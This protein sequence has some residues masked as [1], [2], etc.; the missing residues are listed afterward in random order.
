MLE[1]RKTPL[2]E[3]HVEAGGR[4]VDFGG[5]ALPVQYTSILEE[6]RA[7]RERAGLFDVSHMGEIH[8][9]GPDA[10]AFIQ[11]LVT[12][13]CSQMQVHQIV[14]SP[15]CYPDGGVVDDILVY[16]VC[17]NAYWL[18]VNA[19]NT[20]KDYEW[21]VRNAPGYDVTVKNISSQVA[22][23]AVQGPAAQTILQ[24]NTDYDLDS[25]KFFWCAPEAMI[26]ERKCLVSRTGYTGED[27]FEIYVAAAEAGRL[28]DRLLE[29]GAE[30]GLRP[31]GLGARDTLRLEAGFMLY[32]NELDESVNPFE[33]VYGRLVDFGKV[34]V[35][36]DA[37]LAARD[38]PATRRL[39]GFALEGRGIARHGYEILREGRVVGVVTSGSFAPT[40]EQSVGM[41]FVPPALAEPGTALE[42]RIRSNR[43][44]ARV[45]PLPFYKRT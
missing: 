15:M 21:I 13:D 7:V 20:D 3:A 24:R 6:H 1:L 16:R 44:A 28:W 26:A 36:R 42:V 41:A 4:I 25:I 27:G 12:N 29:A 43:V 34:F 37:L 8:L 31:A 9:T 22:Q 39:V 2:Y 5:W 40:L 35:G 33:T 18:V 23:I 38:R 11:H 45:V 14:Y 19:S 10:M 32:G 30:D 17:E